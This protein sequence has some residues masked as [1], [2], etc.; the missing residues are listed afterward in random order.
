MGIAF[1][2]ATN[3][4]VGVAN[5]RFMSLDEIMTILPPIAE[6]WL[7]FTVFRKFI[8]CL[9]LPTR[10]LNKVKFF[11]LFVFKARIAA[12]HQRAH[13]ST[14]VESKDSVVEEK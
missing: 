9:N 3:F 14:S 12:T 2:N 8:N 5:A 6:A 7:K 4:R 10:S 1:A 13:M 11:F